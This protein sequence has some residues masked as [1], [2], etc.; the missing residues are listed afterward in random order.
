MDFST[1]FRD[2]CRRGLLMFAVVVCFGIECFS[3][4][5]PDARFP[6]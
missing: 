3:R 2:V 1:S 6:N 4:H 5:S